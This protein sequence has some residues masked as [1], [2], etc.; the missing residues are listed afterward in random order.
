MLRRESQVLSHTKECYNDTQGV[1]D[2]LEAAS[3]SRRRFLYERFIT[4]NRIPDKLNN[5]ADFLITTPKVDLEP[6]KISNSKYQKPMLKREYR[7]G[8]L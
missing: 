5:D 3:Q 2:E 6:F 4:D 7:R 1:L 8:T